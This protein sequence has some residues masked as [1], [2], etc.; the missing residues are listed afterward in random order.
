MFVGFE[1]DL[2]L[3]TASYNSKSGKLRT[4]SPLLEIEDLRVGYLHYGRVLSKEL[5]IGPVLPATQ[6][7]LDCC[8]LFSRSQLQL[9][10]NNV[11]IYNII[12]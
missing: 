11:T 6:D 5:C 10:C 9:Q 7:P 4:A 2:R 8:F 12:I 1:G 3:L